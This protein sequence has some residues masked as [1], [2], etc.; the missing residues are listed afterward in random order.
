L[1]KAEKSAR[2]KPSP[3]EVKARA[4]YAVL[5]KA[6]TVEDVAGTQ[7]PVFRG[8]ISEQFKLTG[9]PQS[10]YIV[11]KMLLEHNRC[12]EVVERAWRGTPG[13]VVLYGLPPADEVL[14]MVPRT[15]KDLTATDEFAKLQR[16][17]EK[18]ES[19]VGDIH[20]PSVLESIA[21][22]LD[23]GEVTNG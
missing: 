23:D 15:T 10:Q 13:M 8:Y 19:L 21:Q 16:R 20:L 17:V 12:I 18:L 11:C 3:H 22:R 14:S 1:T 4:F 6:A 9:L 2:V 5:A 7:L